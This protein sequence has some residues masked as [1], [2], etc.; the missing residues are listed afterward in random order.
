MLNYCTEKLTT[1]FGDD[2]KI[3]GPAN[4][5]L[6]SGAISFTYKNYH[7]HDI[8]S[9]LDDKKNVAIRSGQHCAMPLHLEVLNVSATAR[10]SFSIY[11]SKKDVDK[12]I[13]GLKEVDN[14]LK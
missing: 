3:F 14:V 2:I 5:D 8:A 11:N 12:L 10:A 7:P 1:E 4:T 6:R 9:I 13:E